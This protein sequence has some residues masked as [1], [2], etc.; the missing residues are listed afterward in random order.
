[1]LVDWNPSP[2]RGRRL[3]GP[4]GRH[5]HGSSSPTRGFAS[6]YTGGIWRGVSSATPAWC[7]IIGS[8]RRPVTCR[9]L[10]RSENA[11]GRA[12]QPPLFDPPSVR[13]TPGRDRE[14]AGS[15]WGEAT[16]PSAGERSQFSPVTAN[17]APETKSN[18]STRECHVP[19]RGPA[20]RA[21][22]HPPT[23]REGV[24]SV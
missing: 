9:S 14:S 13:P 21:S 1:M 7:P 18:G 16:R 17:A 3:P 6:H 2:A 20:R 10:S 8:R 12:A 15:G 24:R 23:P 5:G 22:T 19:P 4:R 11:P